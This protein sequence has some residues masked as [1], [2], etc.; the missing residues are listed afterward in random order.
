MEKQRFVPSKW[1]WAVLVVLLLAAIGFWLIP[2]A[3]PASSCVAVLSIDGRDA[4]S[5]PLEQDSA[6]QV[7]DLS[8]Y[9][10]PGELHLNGGSICF[11]N[12]SCPD[13][14]CEQYGWLSKPDQ[15][16]ICL[17]NRATLTIFSAAEY[18]ARSPQ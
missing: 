6:E 11:Q 2:K 14:I 18:S 16:A 4:L 9:G 10:M 5:I 3:L 15:I 8:A 12:V 1:E 13:H 7:I 17:P